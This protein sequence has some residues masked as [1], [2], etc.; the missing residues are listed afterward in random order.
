MNDT[1]SWENA[2]SFCKRICLNGDLALI[3]DQAAMD[4]IKSNVALWTSTWI[5][6]KSSWSSWS[7]TDGT[8][9]SYKNW[10]YHEPDNYYSVN[11]AYMSSGSYQ[12]YDGSTSDYCAAL[13]QCE[14]R[15][16][17]IFP[18]NVKF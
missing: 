1:M 9:L 18:V 8:Y 4:F 2:R 11:V 5:G 7:W 17:G 3:K 16:T 13:C 6:A 15:T 14:K 10:V 12:W